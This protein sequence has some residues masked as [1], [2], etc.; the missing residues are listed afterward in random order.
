VLNYLLRFELQSVDEAGMVSSQWVSVALEGELGTLAQL[1]ST[2]LQEGF[3][4][5]A[6]YGVQFAG[7]GDMELLEV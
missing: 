1:Q 2:A 7:I 4:L 5:A 6:R 3:S